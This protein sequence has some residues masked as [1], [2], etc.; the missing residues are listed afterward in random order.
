[1]QWLLQRALSHALFASFFPSLSGQ[2]ILKIRHSQMRGSVSHQSLALLGAGGW[3]L[4]TRLSQ[5]NACYRSLNL[6]FESEHPWK[7]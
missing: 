4:G 1:M 6:G 3:S 5:Q 7:Y 2:N